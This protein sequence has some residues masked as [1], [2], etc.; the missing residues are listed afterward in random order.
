M[1]SLGIQNPTSRRAVSQL[2]K[3][4][5]AY[6]ATFFIVGTADY[7]APEETLLFDTLEEA[8]RALVGQ[9][10]RI[11]PH[12]KADVLEYRVPEDAI[13]LTGGPETPPD[14][15]LSV[16]VSTPTGEALEDAV[17]AAVVLHDYLFAGSGALQIAKAL[18]LVS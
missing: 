17:A 10:V 7:P 1:L 2:F 4:A 18:G 14:G 8:Q 15:L 13:F 9:I 6:G 3:V 16:R 12:G 11:N 5:R